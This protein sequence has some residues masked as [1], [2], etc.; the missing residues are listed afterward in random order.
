M[1]NIVEF[2]GLNLSMEINNVAFS[3]FSFPIYWYGICIGVGMILA[4]LFAFTQAKRFGIDADR[5]IDVVM[6][7][8]VCAIVGGRLYYVLFVDQKY[9]SFKELIDLRS[10]G[11]AIYGGIIGAFVGAYF[12]CRW[13]KVPIAPM[14]DL[15]AMGFL[16]GQACGRWGNF[17][18]QEAFGS[19]TTLPWG[20]RSETTTA[21]LAGQQAKLAAQGIT[22]DPSLPVHPTFLY[23]SLWC[24]LGFALLFLYRKRRKFNGEI[25]LF[26]I[27]WYGLGRFVIEGLRTDSLMIGN[28]RVSQMLAAT[29]VLAALAI[30]AILRMKNR[31]KALVVPEIPPH[32]AKVRVEGEE[33]PVVISWPA[34]EKEPTKEEK[35]RMAEVLLADAL[36]ADAEEDEETGEETDTEA[37]ATDKEKERDTP[38]KTENE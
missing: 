34:D 22:V 27:A 29:S 21:Y 15:A 36:L 2:P 32:T 23:E 8:L 19:N 5:M 4:L 33:S 37:D 3:I 7:G 24:L 28:L 1:V 14:F 31:G 11:I 30:W 16:I 25:F 26:Y 10:G 38:E 12:A 35:L 6:I 13:R 17:F 18:N 9:A 20:M